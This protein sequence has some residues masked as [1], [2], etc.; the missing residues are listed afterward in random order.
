MRQVRMTPS[1]L[2]ISRLTLTR[3]GPPTGQGFA[4]TG[5]SMFHSSNG[6]RGVGF[7]K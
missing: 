4:V 2:R 6:I 7:S 1:Y 3:L 5:T